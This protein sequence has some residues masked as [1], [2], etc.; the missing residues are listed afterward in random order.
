[1]F[2][3]K[4]WINLGQWFVFENTLNQFVKQAAAVS[5]PFTVLL[6][7]FEAQSIT[8]VQLPFE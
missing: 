6:E 4:V 3:F 7:A 2:H 5:R 8:L 1:M